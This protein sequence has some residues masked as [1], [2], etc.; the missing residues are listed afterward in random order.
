MN[1]IIT[2]VAN[3]FF[4]VFITTRLW[5]LLWVSWINSIISHAISKVHFNIIL[6]NSWKRT[7]WNFLVSA[8]LSYFLS[9]CT[10]GECPREKFSHGTR[11]HAVRH[12]ALLLCL[13]NLHEFVQRTVVVGERAFKFPCYCKLSVLNGFNPRPSSRLNEQERTRNS[14]FPVGN[15]TA[16]DAHG[17]GNSSQFHPS[18]T[19]QVRKYIR[20]ILDLDCCNAYR[21]C[22][23]CIHGRRSC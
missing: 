14:Q 7:F 9:S 18:P 12:G 22:G 15:V 10:A 6:N 23:V 19:G 11:S 21:I 13:L 8:T 16:S 2:K 17:D 5:N 4:I 20:N 1:L 3:K